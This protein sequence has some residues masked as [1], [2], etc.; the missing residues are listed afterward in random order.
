[1]DKMDKLEIQNFIIHSHS[2]RISLFP[3]LRIYFR[4]YTDTLC[5]LSDL[6]LRRSRSCCK[7]SDSSAIYTDGSLMFVREIM[8][9]LHSSCHI[10]WFHKFHLCAFSN[11][12]LFPLHT[13]V[14]K[15]YFFIRDSS[16]SDVWMITLW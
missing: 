11:E 15:Y 12:N 10:L 6:Y 2:I 16:I 4:R 14:I 3:F 5:R 8:V 7:V 1:M 9:S 13:T